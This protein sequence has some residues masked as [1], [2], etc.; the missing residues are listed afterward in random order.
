[1]PKKLKGTSIDTWAGTGG[2]EI[3]DHSGEF[4]AAFE[5]AVD[6]AMEAIG[7]QAASHAKQNLN[8]DPK[9]IDTGLLRNSITHAVAGKGAAQK[10][11]GPDNPSKY[12]GKKPSPRIY[13]GVAPAAGAN[14]KTVYIGTNV[15]YAVYVHEPHKTPSGKIVPPNRF[16]KN[17]VKGHGKEYRQILADYLRNG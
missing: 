14:E 13:S 10:I 5:E 11:Y 7:H 4:L 6:A 16:L 15:K 17:A 2:M 9:R 12:S 8:R 1:M 3:V